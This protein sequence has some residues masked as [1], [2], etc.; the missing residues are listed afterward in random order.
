MLK[1]YA[2]GDGTGIEYK[3]QSKMIDIVDYATRNRETVSFLVE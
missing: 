3:L 2:K 1:G